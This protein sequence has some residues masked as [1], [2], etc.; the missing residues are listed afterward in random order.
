MLFALSCVQAFSAETPLPELL[1]M[2]SGEKVS[3]PEQWKARRG[4]LLEVF[5]S[6]VYGRNAVERPESLKFKVTETDPKA[7]DGKATRKAVTISYAGAGGE[8]TI[9]LV[10]FVP[11]ERTKPAPAFV[12]LCNRPAENID[13]TREKKSAFWPAEQIVARGYAAAAFLVADV[14]ED[15]DDN[16]KGGVHGIFDPKDKARGP[17]AWGT[18]AAWAW[19]GSRV[20]DYFETDG[21]IDAKRVAMIGHSRGG[22]T[23]LW[24]GASDERFAMAVS[25]DSGCTGAAIAKGKKG[26]RIEKINASFP[27]WFCSNYKNYNGKDDELPFDQHMLVAL[28]APRPVCVAS[29]TLD[30]WAH[31]EHEFL[32]CVEASPAWELFGKK[33][34]VA[35]KFPEPESPIEEGMIGY[36]LRTGK[37]DLNEYDWKCYLDFADKR[38]K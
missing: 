15:K 22:K 30:T 6:Q 28:M 14:D 11:N 10:L 4:E 23:A 27:H 17:D 19:G 33:G 21:D 5:R 1:K 2:Q 18:I 9:H 12:L 35:T 26:E 31:P 36:H 29:A 16:F 8:G 38:L 3:T 7:M 13:P 25:N 20:M 37:H 24:C 34:V 32:A